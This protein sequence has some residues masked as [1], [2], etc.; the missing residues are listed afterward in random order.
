MEAS[1]CVNDI[2]VSYGRK[3]IIDGLSC[4][5][6][7]GDL[8]ALVGPNGCGKSTLLHAIARVLPIE[9][10]QVLLNNIDIHNSP[11][12]QVA[13]KLALLPQG[14]VAPEGLTVHELVSQGRFPHQSLIRQ[15]SVED[16]AAIDKALKMTFLTEFSNRQV[17][18]LSGG[19]RQR[20]WIAM[21][22]AQETPALLL[23]EP[24][25]F[26]DLKVQVELM[27]LLQ[28]IARTENRT[29]LVVLHDLNVAAAFADRMIMMRDGRLVAD[30][31]VNSVFTAANLKTVFDL[32]A[33]IVQDPISGR[34][35]CV[36][37]T[38]GF[39]TAAE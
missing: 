30:G 1:I 12:R 3:Q 14:P 38:N 36:P 28:R 22:L 8:T 20:C 29:V 39:S 15:W 11:T 17:S 10:G 32:E 9:R 6:V 7:A 4:R 23:D 24:T 37:N 19:Q 16:A 33:S 5:A 31:P 35:V 27:G 26:L 21:V 34:P 18:T 25:T 13:R 2:S